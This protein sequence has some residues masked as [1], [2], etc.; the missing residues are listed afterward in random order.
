[1]E[2]I[3]SSP[4]NHLH[5]KGSPL[6]YKGGGASPH[7]GNGFPHHIMLCMI[8]VLFLLL[9]QGLGGRSLRKGG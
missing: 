3:F 1:M 6:I 4:P 7:H 9:H 5:Y 2:I 8:V